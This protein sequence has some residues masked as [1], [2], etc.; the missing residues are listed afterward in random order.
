MASYITPITNENVDFLVEELVKNNQINP[1]D[2][3]KFNVKN[4][5]ELYLLLIQFEVE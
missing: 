3:T 2:F 5:N 1:N 4:I